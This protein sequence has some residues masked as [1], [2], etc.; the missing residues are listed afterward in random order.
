MEKQVALPRHRFASSHD[1]R[2][3]VKTPDTQDFEHKFLKTN[4]TSYPMFKNANL[5]V[6]L[7]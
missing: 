3:E 1:R 7:K 2:Q 6:S 4:G 5:T